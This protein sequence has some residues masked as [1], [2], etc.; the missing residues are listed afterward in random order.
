M[1]ACIYNIL[2]QRRTILPR[3]GSVGDRAMLRQVQRAAYL[4]QIGFR[5]DVVD[6]WIA[7]GGSRHQATAHRPQLRSLG[8]K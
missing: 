2:L 1:D 8:T 3:A 6:G 5:I 7:G 4:G